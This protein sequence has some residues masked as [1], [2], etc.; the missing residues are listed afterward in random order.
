M[1]DKK[2]FAS[3]KLQIEA[4]KA[5]PAPPVGPALGPLGINIMDFC[6]QF[7]EKTASQPGMIIPVVITAYVDKSFDFIMK[8]P[9]VAVLLKK[10]AKIEKASQKPKIIP[11]ATVSM[12][13]VRKIAEQKMVDLNASD[14]EAAIKMVIGTGKSMG[15][16]VKE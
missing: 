3:A 7:N 12:E 6:K 5:T 11:S 1:A 2:I 16:T 15:I 10:A 4:G 14:I 9:P 8:T 13:D